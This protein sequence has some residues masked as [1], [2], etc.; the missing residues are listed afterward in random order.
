MTDGDEYWLSVPG[1][2]GLYEASSLGRVRSLNHV[3]VRLGRTGAIER[4][5]HFGKV[6]SPSHPPSAGGY[7]RV[8]LY[9]EGVK[10]D[11]GLHVVVCLAFHGR[12]QPGR[13]A[14]HRNGNPRDNAPSN[15][16]WAT[17]KENT[18]DAISHGTIVEG[19]RHKRSKLNPAK[20]AAI[21]EGAA[22]GR[23]I[24]SLSREHQVAHSTAARVVHGATWKR[25][26]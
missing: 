19:I 26:G 15:L 10:S 8:T 14:A 4:C 25:C 20:V 16:R 6:L 13:V 21:R 22:A 2:E 23:T 5:S 18:R 11:L 7:G 17:P 9:R 12:P 24:T 1:Y 3:K